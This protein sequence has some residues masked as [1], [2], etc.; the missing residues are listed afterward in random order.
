ME[1]F[2][3]IHEAVC[4]TKGNAGCVVVGGGGYARQESICVGVRSSPSSFWALLQAQL[5]WNVICGEMG[6]SNVLD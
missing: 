6:K 2:C 4:T 1:Y 5:E 3:R